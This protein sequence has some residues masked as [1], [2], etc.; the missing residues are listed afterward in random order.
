M[1]LVAHSCPSARPS[2]QRD[3]GHNRGFTLIELMVVVAIIGILSAIAY[4]SYTE[5]IAKS[6]RAE[7]RAQLLEVGQFMQRFYSQND[8]YD[9]TNAAPAVAATIPAALATVPKG[10]SVASANY[11]ISFVANSLLPN[12][13]SLSAVRVNSMVNDKCGTLLLNS[14][15]QR[16]VTGA[17]T[18]MT[19]E[20]CWR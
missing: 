3:R 20:T 14:V 9:Q 16:T 10:A 19:A 5:S 8:R 17:T 1:K 12:A 6:K 4:P 18:P 15:G 13:F 2:V 7:A 11:T